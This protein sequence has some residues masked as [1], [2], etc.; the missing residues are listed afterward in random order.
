MSRKEVEGSGSMLTFFS[1]SAIQRYIPRIN[2]Q[3]Q[4]LRVSQEIFQAFRLAYFLQ[5]PCFIYSCCMRGGITVLERENI[6][7]I[8]EN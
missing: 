6:Y 8:A 7:C 5:K 1:S 2:N 4:A 3:G